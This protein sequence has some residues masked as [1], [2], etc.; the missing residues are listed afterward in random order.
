MKQIEFINENKMK[1]ETGLKIFDKQ[2]NLV[3]TGSVIANTQFSMY[4]RSFDTVK[5]YGDRTYRK[6]DLQNFDLAYFKGNIPSYI[7]EKIRNLGKDR[8]LYVYEFFHVNARKEKSV[9][10]YVV[11]TKDHEFLEYFVTGTS[12]SYLVIKECVQYVSDYNH[13]EHTRE[14]IAMV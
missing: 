2:T 14:R 10:G 3:T 11:T 13:I 5:A 12:K 7:L 8:D 1:M 6:G 4:I 9:H